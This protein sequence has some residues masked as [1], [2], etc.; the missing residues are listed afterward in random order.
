MSAEKIVNGGGAGRD[1]SPEL[2]AA[3]RRG[4]GSVRLC[5]RSLRAGNRGRQDPKLSPEQEAEQELER[6]QARVRAVTRRPLLNLRSEQYQ[7]VG[8]ATESFMKLT[9]NDC[10]SLARELPRAITR[11]TGLTSNDRRAA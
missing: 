2:A 5:R 3:S 8:D 4:R 6:A 11:N 1:R 9:L 10:E 7:A